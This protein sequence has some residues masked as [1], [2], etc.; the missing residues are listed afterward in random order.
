MTERWFSPKPNPSARPPLPTKA[1][2]QV[3]CAL[4]ADSTRSA[5][6]TRRGALRDILVYGLRLG[7]LGGQAL[8]PG[9]PVAVASPMH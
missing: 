9:N 5:P 4:V 6:P 2:P 8:T 1:E 7:D 3:S